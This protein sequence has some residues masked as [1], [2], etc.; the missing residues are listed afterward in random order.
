MIFYLFLD[1]WKKEDKKFC[2][3]CTGTYDTLGE[4]KLACEKEQ[5]CNVIYDLFCDNVGYFCICPFD[6]VVEQTHP[7]GIDCIHVKKWIGIQKQI[8][9]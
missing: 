9:G 6:S 7:R 1:G 8:T 3:S 2:P 5:D 4:A